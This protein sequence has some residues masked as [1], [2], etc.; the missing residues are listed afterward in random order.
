M[1]ITSQNA[2]EMS[3][4]RWDADAAELGIPPG[5]EFPASIETDLGNG[6]PFQFQGYDGDRAGFYK[7]AYGCLLLKVWN[8]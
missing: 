3:V 7:Q 6:Q 4:H 5:I 8:D 2:R 1:K